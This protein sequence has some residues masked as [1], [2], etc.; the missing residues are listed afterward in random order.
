MMGQHSDHREARQRDL[1]VCRRDGC[2]AQ[3]GFLVFIRRTPGRIGIAKIR[4]TAPLWL[5]RMRRDWAAIVGY[6][7]LDFAIGLQADGDNLP[8]ITKFTVKVYDSGGAEVAGWVAGNWARGAGW[9]DNTVDGVAFGK[10]E[11]SCTTMRE[12]SPL[13]TESS[14]AFRLL[15]QGNDARDR[16][17]DL[18]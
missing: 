14:R 13:I 2:V 3:Y 12:D 9:T 11:R 10:A 18:S 16:N 5:Q 15:V 4:W 8:T 7:T 1:V 6:P 17:R